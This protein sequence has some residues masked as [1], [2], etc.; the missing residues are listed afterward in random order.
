M[1]PQEGG[2]VCVEVEGGELAQW[3]RGVQTSG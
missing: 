1:L 3:V 2:A